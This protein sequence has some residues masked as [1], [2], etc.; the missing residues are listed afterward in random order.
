MGWRTPEVRIDTTRPQPRSRIPGNSLLASWIGVTER[1]WNASAQPS[2]VV[3]A[4]SAV[5]GPPALRITMSTTPYPSS[6]CLATVSAADGSVASAATT[7]TSVPCRSRSSSAVRSRASLDRP[8]CTAGSLRL[9]GDRP[10]RGRG[11]TKRHRPAPPCPGSRDPSRP[12]IVSLGPKVWAY[13]PGLTGTSRLYLFIG[14]R[15]TVSVMESHF[16]PAEDL[17]ALYRAVLDGVD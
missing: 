8:R 3:W 14:A 7:M 12:P 6:A 4:G 5:G 1:S 13:Q 17:P 15:R 11:R 9:P 2:G 10:W 16:S